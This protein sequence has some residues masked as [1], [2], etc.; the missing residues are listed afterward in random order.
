[1]LRSIATTGKLKS[2]D[3]VELNVLLDRN[4]MTSNLAIDLL[5]WTFRHL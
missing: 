3:F 5:D 2:M 1:M 4:D